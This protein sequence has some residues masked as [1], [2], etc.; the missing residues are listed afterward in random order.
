MQENDKV[1]AP[2]PIDQPRKSRFQQFVNNYHT[3]LSS[4]VIGAAGLV[5]TTVYQSKQQDIARRQANA[6]IEVAKREADT[7]WRIERAE[8]LAK[9]LQVLSGN[10]DNEVEKFGVLLSLSRG[11]IIDPELAISYA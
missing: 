9:N 2:A 4:F 6:Q 11:D 10:G 3:F 7:K 1:E 5:A 8:I